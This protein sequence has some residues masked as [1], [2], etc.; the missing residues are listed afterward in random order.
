M[1]TPKHVT[2]RSR[3]GR[4]RGDGHSRKGSNGHRRKRSK[5]GSDSG[6]ENI[7]PSDNSDRRKRKRR[8]QHPR[9]SST[10]GAQDS[11]HLQSGSPN[12][13][14][15][16]GLSHQYP[17]GQAAAGDL[18]WSEDSFQYPEGTIL[19]RGNEVFRIGESGDK[20]PLVV[21]SR[22]L[23]HGPQKVIAFIPNGKLQASG[24]S[25]TFTGQYK[26]TPAQAPKS[27]GCCLSYSTSEGEPAQLEI[28]IAELQRFGD[29]Y[30]D[31]VA[32]LRELQ[33]GY[34]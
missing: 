5:S 9:R 10:M 27:K 7:N 13:W 8:R 11:S 17:T 2:K 30:M 6:H 24:T 15:T 3:K 28:Q 20:E 12:N 14:G 4:K 19:C 33:T 21:L 29:G 34:M 18:V 1:G 32:L 16:D 31:I 22:M 25:C 23:S 26:N